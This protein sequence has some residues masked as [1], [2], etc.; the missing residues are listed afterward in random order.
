MRGFRE[1]RRQFPERAALIRLEMHRRSGW[2][3]AIDGGFDALVS[4][5]LL[6][7]ATAGC[8][9]YDSKKRAAMR[10]CLAILEP[11][12]ASAPRMRSVRKSKR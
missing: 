12:S 10:A 11:K 7:V 1:L 4:D 9:G 5:L 3:V 2:K 8:N 6:H